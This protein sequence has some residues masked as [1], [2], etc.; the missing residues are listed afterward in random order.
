MNRRQAVGVL[1]S[2]LFSAR[3]ALAQEWAPEFTAIDHIEFFVSDVP[4]ARDFYAAVFGREVLKNAA[5]A[6]NYVRLGAS[7]MAF[8]RPRTAGAPLATDHVSLSIR[9]IDMAR[10]HAF[11]DARGIAYRD[12][13]SGRDTAIVDA[14][15]IRTQLSPE[16][17]WN[18]LKPPTFAPDEDARVAEPVFQ[19][20]AIEHVL[21][22]V[23]DPAA[24]SPFYEKVLGPAAAR[25]DGVVWFNVGRARLGLQKTTAGQRTGVHH[26]AVAAA[27]FDT[28]ATGERLKRLGATVEPS[29][30]TG[31]IAFRDPDGMLVHV[32]RSG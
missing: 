30:G 9:S 25:A 14:D 6:K 17:G 28:A 4:R 5:A 18:L 29:D 23:A 3:Y 26:F 10:V 31:T 2:A 12:Y 21:L 24:A 8:E 1:A 15:G 16:N 13:P 22:Y 7:Y 32:R 11:L 19:P 20:Q 27:R